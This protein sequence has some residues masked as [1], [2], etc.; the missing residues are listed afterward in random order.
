VVTI[1]V[2]GPHLIM[3]IAARSLGGFAWFGFGR[4]GR[5]GRA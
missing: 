3:V 5:R 4:P 1:G 2:P